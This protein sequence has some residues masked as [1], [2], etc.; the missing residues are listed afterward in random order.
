MPA[1]KRNESPGLCVIEIVICFTARHT[2]ISL[3]TVRQMSMAAANP[4]T[5][6]Y[7]LLSLAYEAHDTLPP[8][9]A[10]P[11]WDERTL[12][13]AYRHCESV[14][15]A[16]SKSFSL[17]TSLLPAAK[18]R[19][20]RAL[21]AFCR[22]SDNLVDCCPDNAAALLAAW[23]KKVLAPHPGSDDPILIAWTDARLRYRVP[24]AYVEQFLD[25]VARDLR[26]TRYA[27]FDELAAYAYGVAS[28]VGL[29]SMHIIGCTDPAAVPYAIKLGVALQLTNILRDVSEDWQRG[30][31]YLPLEELAA[32]GL[33]ENDI[34]AGQ[35]DDRW[36]ALMRFQITRARRLYAETQPGIA[37]LNPDGRLAVTAA[38]ELYRAIL[39]DI[40]THDY[41]V[42][43]R[44]AHVNAWDK[45][46]RLPDIWWHSRK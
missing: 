2:R 38:A 13:R 31:L 3:Q 16:S 27:T 7:T 46:R 40:E 4:R 45:L 20:I 42:F 43:S 28:T 11:A 17:A 21:Y 33:A 9:T 41:N 36:R 26:Q 5:W 8:T 22:T 10:R 30:R 34:A 32:Y 6:E 1:T 18:R 14:T 15:A 39:Q 24:L 23:R 12:A 35:V 19:A 25:G 29:M 37:V 44:R